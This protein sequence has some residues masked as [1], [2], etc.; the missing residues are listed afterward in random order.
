MGK[1]I[2][3]FMLMFVATILFASGPI[4]FKIAVN[5]GLA[6]G[7]TIF[8]F[9]VVASLFG[10]ITLRN[11]P[12]KALSE[13]ETGKVIIAGLAWAIMIIAYVTAFQMRT[14]TETALL[15]GLAPIF[16]VILTIILLK[17]KVKNYSLL[18]LSL[19]VGTVS[20]LIFIGEGVN[21]TT[22]TISI[23][24]LILGTLTAMSAA[25]TRI[26]RESLSREGLPKETIMT[27]VTAVAA[28][29]SLVYIVLTNGITE[30]LLIL[31]NINQTLL[32][33]FMGI[34]TVWVPGLLTLKATEMAG[35]LSKL[36]ILDYSTPILTA[37]IA[38]ALVGE[39]GFEY[40]TLLISF[41]G[42]AVAA[43]LINKAI[44]K[45]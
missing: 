8:Y 44:E 5:T 9:F 42:I 15:V 17:E 32:I 36:N 14:I 12:K 11:K 31:P 37:L 33:L 2:K 34:G 20:V 35:S 6:I 43:M 40:I 18:F 29:F 45:K 30:Q 22:G 26:T 24:F 23:T 7:N 27:Y 25:I 3:A 41:V 4:F 10:F 28:L 13:K 16:S 19:I 38:F 39:R 1:T 21:I